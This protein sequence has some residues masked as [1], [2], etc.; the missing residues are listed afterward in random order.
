M[1][2]A[3]ETASLPPLVSKGLAAAAGAAIAATTQSSRR[4]RSPP[5]HGGS[6]ETPAEKKLPSETFITRP[7]STS[8]RTC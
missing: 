1:K 5:R 2:D 6:G 3:S 4:Q 7:G 8:W